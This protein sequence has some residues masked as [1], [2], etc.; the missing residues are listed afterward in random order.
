MDAIS[1]F[2]EQI[3]N[4]LKLIILSYEPYNDVFRTY[5]YHHV[6][7]EDFEQKLAEVLF[8]SVVFYAFEKDEIENDY[9]RGRLD[10]LRKAARSAYELRVPKTEKTTDG[11]MGE[12]ALDSFIKCFFDEIELLYSRVKYL[13]KIPQSKEIPDRKGHEVKGYDG[14]V[15]SKENGQK[16]MWVGQVKTGTWRYCFDGI[17][18]DINKSILSYYFSSAMVIL[19]DIMRAIDNCSA[20]LQKIINDINDILLDYP[21]P[22]KERDLK[23]IDY[24][25]AEEIVIRIPCMI[26]AEEN[27][28]E[29]EVKLLGEVKQKCKEAFS[30][31]IPINQ[32]EL[33]TEI[34]LMVF[35]V[36]DINTLREN[37]LEVRKP[38]GK[39]SETN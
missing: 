22:G 7:E 28:Y 20:E 6:L 16:Y 12:L 13:E 30:G 14:L 27:D 15:F 33:N 4:R 35:P 3:G 37:F 21:Y 36:R 9:K 38:D 34:V 2:K 17:K 10:N 26:I 31:F 29:D 32:N 8:D 25:K 5:P 24:F 1:I 19:A 11:L 23:I 39:Q 18:D